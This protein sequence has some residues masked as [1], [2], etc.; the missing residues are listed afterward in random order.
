[1]SDI[2]LFQI[3]SKGVSELR[4]SAMTLERSLQTLIEKNMES[5]LVD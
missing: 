4:G 3:N 1:M 2:K 5:F